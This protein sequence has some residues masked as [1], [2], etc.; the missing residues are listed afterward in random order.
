MRY[1]IALLLCFV[2]LVQAETVHEGDFFVAGE[3]VEIPDVVKG[4]V[5]AMGSQIHIKGRVEGDLVATG[6]TIE[7]DGEVLGNARLIGGQVI[8]N[9]TIRNNVTAIGGNLQMNRG[10]T[11][12][13]NASFSGG[14]VVIEGE[15]AGKATL[16]ASTAEVNGKIGKNL[17]GREGQ[18]RLG[19]KSEIGG[20]LDYKSGNKAVIAPGAKI[21][22]EV[23]YSP[24]EVKA[25]LSSNWKNR[26]IFGSWLLAISMNFLF[27][28]VF[29]VIYIKW[30]H[31]GFRNALQALKARPWKAAGVGLLALILLPLICVLLLVSILGFPLAL[32]LIAFSLITFYTAKVIPIIWIVHAVFPKM[33]VYWALFLG[34]IVFFI[35]LQIPFFGWILS[36]CFILLGLGA[37]FLSQTRLQKSA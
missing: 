31:K 34:L 37:G 27:S 11:I 19:A 15:I 36:F 5:Y 24:S 20:N 29:G 3:N 26:V 14:G 2:S 9:G 7:V 10:A 8:L 18:L 33:S 17:K 22:G 25:Y 32:V 6:G 28:F 4:D 23:I 13:G 12:G 16:N 35:L 30:F 1:I 21:G